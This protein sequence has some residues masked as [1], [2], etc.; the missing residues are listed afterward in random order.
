VLQTHDSRFGFEAS[1]HY[2]YV[3]MDLAEKILCCRDLLDRWLP[4]EREKRGI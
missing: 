2:F 1:N 4:A 3:P